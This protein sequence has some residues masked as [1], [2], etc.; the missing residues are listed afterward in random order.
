M[1][2]LCIS[3]NSHFLG[4]L[5]EN[6]LLSDAATKHCVTNSIVH[7]LAIVYYK[8]KCLNIFVVVAESQKYKTTK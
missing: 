1:A 6:N 8:Y 2:L 4:S 3:D 7:S 5:L